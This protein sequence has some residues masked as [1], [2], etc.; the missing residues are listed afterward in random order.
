L[1]ASREKRQNKANAEADKA[2]AQG[3]DDSLFGDLDYK[4]EGDIDE[5]NLEDHAEGKVGCVW[6]LRLPL[7]QMN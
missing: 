1:K 3:S 7:C 5:Q 6:T 4:L 2:A